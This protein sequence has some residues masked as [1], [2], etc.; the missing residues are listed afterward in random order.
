MELNWST[1]LLE[2]INFLVLVWIL[3]HFL[4]RPVLDLVARRRERIEQT[5]VEARGELQAGKDLQRQFESRLADWER[6]KETALGALQRELADMRRQRLKALD[7][8]LADQREKDRVLARRERHE[9]ERRLESRALALGANFAARLMER[10]AAPDLE[11]RL[12]AMAL[13]DMAAITQTQRKSLTRAL[14]ENDA[15]AEVI[16]TYTLDDGQ[17]QALQAALADLAGFE[18]K[19]R[20]QEDPNLIA[21]LRLKL[22]SWVLHANLHDELKGFAEAGHG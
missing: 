3:K 16:S 12:V 11:K 9:Q 1:F 14:R 22:G 5:L 13:E 2:I 18:V 19:C 4:Y 20:Y 21:G 17:R 7:A 15:Q 6:E 10:V 8:E